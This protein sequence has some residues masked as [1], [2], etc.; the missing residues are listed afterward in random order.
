MRFLETQHTFVERT[1]GRWRCDA[2]PESSCG[3]LINLYQV[4]S[5]LQAL[6]QEC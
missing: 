1:L 3:N 2:P 4:Q 6:A 5:L